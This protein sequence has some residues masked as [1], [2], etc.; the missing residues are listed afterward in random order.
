MAEAF[1]PVPFMSCQHTPA[2]DHHGISLHS[3]KLNRNHPMILGTRSTV[4]QST[5]HGWQQHWE[6]VE[7]G[8]WQL[9][10]ARL[11]CNPML[12]QYWVSTGE[13]SRGSTVHM[14]PG[15]AIQRV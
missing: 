5:G 8:R 12:G 7:K 11:D 14:L 3:F 6:H 10:E 4:R 15:K 2:Q 13:V 9:W 1:K